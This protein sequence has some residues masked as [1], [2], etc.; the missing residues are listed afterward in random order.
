MAKAFVEPVS[1]KSGTRYRARWDDPVTGNEACRTFKLARDA[2]EFLATITADKMTGSYADPREGRMTLAAYAE[3]WVAAQPWETS[4]RLKNEGKLRRHILPAFGDRP[5]ISITPT[6]VQGFSTRLGRTMAASTARDVFFVLTALLK[7]AHRDRKIPVDP[8][9]HV[10]PPDKV[11]TSLTIP[12]P[13]EVA[14]LVDAAR[15]YSIEAAVLLAAGAGLRQS[16][17]TGL[18][19]DAITFPMGT[20]I[21]GVERGP[22]PH[23]SVERTLACL[24]GL[25]TFLKAPKSKAGVR[26]ITAA[27]RLATILTDHVQAHPPVTV[28]LPWQYPTGKLITVKLLF[29]VDGKPIDRWT[30]ADLWNAAVRD[31]GLRDIHFHALR[32]YAVSSLI[33]HGAT[34]KEVQVFAGHADHQTTWDTYGHLWPDSEDRIGIGIDAALDFTP[35]RHL[36]VVEG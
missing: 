3:L 32:H 13:D 9:M 25:P 4:T 23:L 17:V 22:R 16:E 20:P 11:K 26:T 5:L 1:R 30:F 24:S 35:A 18:A 31:A 28:H 7:A 12:T 19:L 21:L 6:E 2:R 36:R 8:S 10:S 27:G 34:P 14:A 15:P 29:T 33:R